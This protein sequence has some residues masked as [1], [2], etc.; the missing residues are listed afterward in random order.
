LPAVDGSS[1]RRARRKLQKIHNAR[2]YCGRRREF[3]F[4]Q[5]RCSGAECD[6]HDLRDRSLYGTD[7]VSSAN[8]INSMLPE[9]LA[10]VRGYVGHYAASPVLHLDA[11]DQFHCSGPAA[12]DVDFFIALE[13]TS[14]PH[15]RITVRNAGPGLDPG[16]GDDRV[17]AR[18]REHHYRSSSGGRRRTVVLYGTGL[19]RTEPAAIPGQINVVRAQI[20]AVIDLRVVVGDA[21]LDGASIVYGLTP[22]STGLR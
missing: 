2:L 15:V 22:G 9:V 10:G 18:R 17:H 19:G 16:T 11:A 12:G 7:R 20:Q 14:G 1:R 3:S 6:C 4:E 13:G 8:I 21:T 5:R